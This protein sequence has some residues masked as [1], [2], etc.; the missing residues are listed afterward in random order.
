[1]CCTPTYKS[2]RTIVLIIGDFGRNEITTVPIL[3]NSFLVPFVI[4]DFLKVLSTAYPASYFPLTCKRNGF[5]IIS[6]SDIEYG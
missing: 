6:L 2:S 3:S 5:T 1:M 4:I